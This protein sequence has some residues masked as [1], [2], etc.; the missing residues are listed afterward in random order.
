ML[1]K[2]FIVKLDAKNRKYKPPTESKCALMCKP[3]SIGIDLIDFIIC[4]RNTDL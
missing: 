1:T 2:R 3:V 4:A